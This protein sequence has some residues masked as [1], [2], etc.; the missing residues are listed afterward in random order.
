MDYKRETEQLD[1]GSKRT[2][3]TFLEREARLCARGRMLV[4][5]LAAAAKLFQ[6]PVD[7]RVTLRESPHR[8]VIVDEDD[9]W[10]NGAGPRLLFNSSPEP[11]FRILDGFFFSAFCF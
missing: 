10:N 2:R 1:I 7:D 4:G 9:C 3:D 5:S 6:I 11:D 8:V